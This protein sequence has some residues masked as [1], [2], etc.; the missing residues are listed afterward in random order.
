[1]TKQRTTTEY[2]TYIIKH[3]DRVRNSNTVRD[4]AFPM[5]LSMKETPRGIEGYCW[6][7]Q[8]PV[9]KIAK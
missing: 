6:N 5:A 8:N 3:A 9:I 2:S 4:C 1:M 7:C